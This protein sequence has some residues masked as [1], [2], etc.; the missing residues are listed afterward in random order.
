[1]IGVDAG[2]H[3]FAS[4]RQNSTSTMRAAIKTTIML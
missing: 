2:L 3:F 4:H 1:V